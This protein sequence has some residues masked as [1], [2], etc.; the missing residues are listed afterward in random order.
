MNGKVDHE[1]FGE[2]ML[3]HNMVALSGAGDEAYLKVK[4]LQDWKPDS[5]HVLIEVPVWSER[6]F[7]V[8]PIKIAIPYELLLTEE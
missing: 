4:V 5:K 3:K 2:M 1:T 7:E 8:F 6:E